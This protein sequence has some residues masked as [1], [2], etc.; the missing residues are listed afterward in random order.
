MDELDRL[1][2]TEL[3]HD[4]RQSIK[5]LSQTIGVAKDTIRRR[6]D[7]LVSSE[8]L[9]L[10]ALPNLNVLGYPL[11]VIIWID[12]E[13]SKI[14]EIANQLCQM[15]FIGFVSYSIG[16]GKLYI[17]GNFPSTPSMINF[18]T[19]RLGRIEGILFIDTM[20]EFEEI[21]RV[22]IRLGMPQLYRQE[23]PQIAQ[24]EINKNDI[25]LIRKL[26]KDARAS[27]KELAQYIGVSQMTIHR[28]IQELVNSG[29]IEFTA[30]LNTDKI[31]YPAICNARVQTK[32]A[33]IRHVADKIAEF[34]QIHYVGIIS[35]PGQLLIGI[36]SP[37]IETIS[38]FLT[39]EL[40]KIDGV[41]KV[42]SF[43][44]MKILK[45]TFTW[46]SE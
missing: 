8:T 18:I 10:T 27:L 19:E 11:R 23:V 16:S 42:E 25:F 41:V 2:I 24:I 33:Q 32:P 9:I 5:K 12:A 31:G 26:Q 46:L 1:I 38:D 28:R 17:R 13:C 34:P 4:P 39:H 30:I 21:K 15:P 6:I 3:Q 43:S 44:F 14:E 45:Q 7:N 36:H 35:G 20:I 37:S 29:T 40:N 22:N